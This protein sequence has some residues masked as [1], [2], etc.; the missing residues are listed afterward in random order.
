MKICLCS[1]FCI[2][3][4]SNTI[5]QT[6]SVSDSLVISENKCDAYLTLQFSDT[7]RISPWVSDS[8]PFNFFIMSPKDSIL[9][10][11]STLTTNETGSKVNLHFSLTPE[12]SFSLMFY[13]AISDQDEQLDK[14]YVK[15]FDTYGTQM[16]SDSLNVVYNLR[17]TTKASTSLGTFFLA[18]LVSK[19]S[20]I[21]NVDNTSLLNKLIQSYVHNI[22]SINEFNFEEDK[23][24]ITIPTKERDS[25][26]IVAFNFQFS[27]TFEPLYYSVADI[28]ESTDPIKTIL[29]MGVNTYYPFDELK[30]FTKPIIDF[31]LSNSIRFNESKL[32]ESNFKLSNFYPNPFNPSTTLTFSVTNSSSISFSVY[33]ILGRSIQ[34]LEHKDVRYSAG[35]HSFMYDFSGL[36]SGTYFIEAIGTELGSGQVSRQ[37]AKVSLVK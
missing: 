21:P 24:S 36:P 29:Y 17:Q 10:K 33:D 28:Y 4:F 30:Q 32:M 12:T 9:I 35:T 2:F 1:L 27:N 16:V 19:K 3:T 18:G 20:M 23:R 34:S 31:Y 22:V 6:L 11:N 26:T 14:P 15:N 8:L 5:A 7:L 37:V 25:L 13:D